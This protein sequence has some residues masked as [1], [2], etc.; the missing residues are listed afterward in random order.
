M[1]HEAVIDLAKKQGMDILP[2]GYT[3][4]EYARMEE[5]QRYPI[6]YELVGVLIVARDYTDKRHLYSQEYTRKREELRQELGSLV[7]E[8]LDPGNPEG[9]I[10]ERTPQEIDEMIQSRIS[11]RVIGVPLI[12]FWLP[13]NP[14]LPGTPIYRDK[15]A[16]V[17]LQADTQSIMQ[18]SWDCVRLR[19]YILKGKPLTGWAAGNCYL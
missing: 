1:L 7:F 6:D 17:K 18:D 4:F 11:L 14:K 10:R 8:E 13:G 15:D 12:K 9:E 19:Q 16:M 3:I 2:K 5:D